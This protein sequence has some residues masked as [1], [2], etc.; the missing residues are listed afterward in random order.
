MTPGRRASISSC[1]WLGWSS[2]CAGSART[3]C[4][5]TFIDADVPPV[6][7]NRGNLENAILN[8]AL[9]AR[10]AMPEG[11]WLSIRAA[12][13]RDSDDTAT[14]VALRAGALPAL[15]TRSEIG[16]CVTSVAGPHGCAQLYER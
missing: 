14:G 2:Y 10:H 7:C 5:S 9:E 4:A 3:T 6:I 15:R 13:S 8:L 12:P 1:V 16:S 11:G